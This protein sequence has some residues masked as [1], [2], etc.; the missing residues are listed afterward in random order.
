MC[1]YIMV[2]NML[3]KE[4]EVGVFI[5]K[6]RKIKIHSQLKEEKRINK[7]PPRR[8]VL[9]VFSVPQQPLYPRED[10]DG[11]GS[12]DPSSVP[13]QYTCKPL[14]GLPRQTLA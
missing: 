3:V 13:A 9:S 1:P 5:Y 12:G 7:M 14:I 8:E 4:T 6:E 2:L 10:G 11:A